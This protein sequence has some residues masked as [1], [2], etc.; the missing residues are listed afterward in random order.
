MA[1][2]APHASHR[3]CNSI[4]VSAQFFVIFLSS[5]WGHRCVQ[6]PLCQP[7]LLFSSSFYTPPSAFPSPS[8]LPLP[9]L[10]W[11]KSRATYHFAVSTFWTLK[12][13]ASD[14]TRS[15]YCKQ[16]SKTQATRKRSCFPNRSSLTA[17]SGWLH[18][19]RVGL[20]YICK[21]IFI[22]SRNCFEKWHSYF[23]SI[24]MHYKYLTYLT[25][26]NIF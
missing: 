4:L 1:L 12:W 21:I 23:Y 25:R 6:S 10:P 24:W 2:G 20:V 5:T 22:K 9:F 8:L 3:I 13:S 18:R 11:M 14:H 16:T 15:Q 26:I 19:I 17:D 7:N